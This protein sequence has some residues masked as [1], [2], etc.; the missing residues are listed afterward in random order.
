MVPIADSSRDWNRNFE[1]GIVATGQRRAA[2]MDGGGKNP[3]V[4]VGFFSFALSM[5]K[6]KP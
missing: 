1:I 3:A 2:E 4:F 5:T 6:S